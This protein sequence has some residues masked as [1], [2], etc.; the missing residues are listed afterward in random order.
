MI[1]FVLTVISAVS[2]CVCVCVCVCRSVSAVL[3]PVPDGS[4]CA[5]CLHHVP[6]PG[7]F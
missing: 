1:W 6:H 5:I 4:C 2:V 7:G 3:R